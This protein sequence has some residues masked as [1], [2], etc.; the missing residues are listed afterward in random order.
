MAAASAAH[1]GRKREGAHAAAERQ[2][3]L[4]VRYR[5]QPLAVPVSDTLADGGQVRNGEQ[6]RNSL[7]YPEVVRCWPST[8]VDPAPTTP[9]ALELARSPHTRPARRIE[10]PVR[11]KFTGGRESAYNPI[12]PSCECS[13]ASLPLTSPGTHAGAVTGT[14]QGF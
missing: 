2:S 6:E 5:Q 14:L 8:A 9:R 12:K 3:H 4:R 10:Q 11:V 1:G 13:C 7:G